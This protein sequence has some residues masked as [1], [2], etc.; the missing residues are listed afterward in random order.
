MHLAAGQGF[1]ILHRALR[2]AMFVLGHVIGDALAL[3]RFA[4]D[5]QDAALHLYA[6]AG[7]ADNAFDEI[8]LVVAGQLEDGD[9]AA[10]GLAFEDAPGERRQA[11]GK[12]MPGIAVGEFGNEQIVAHQ[13]GGDH[14][15][16]GDVEGLVGEGADT[17]GDQ[18]GIK[19]GLDGLA[20]RAVGGFGLLARCRGGKKAGKVEGHVGFQSLKVT[21]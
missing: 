1:Q 2:A 7:Q 9:V 17:Q 10:R 19:H 6:I 14:R 18:T 3:D 4:V 21:G 11:E 20:P 12:G 15:A 5:E 13:Q 16:R 8:G